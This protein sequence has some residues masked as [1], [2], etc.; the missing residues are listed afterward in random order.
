VRLDRGPP[1]RRT[2]Q[3][4][5]DDR[6]H[7]SPRILHVPRDCGTMAFRQRKMNAAAGGQAI[8]LPGNRS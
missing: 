3:I 6:N 4:D 2:R 7:P 8:E 1:V 5:D